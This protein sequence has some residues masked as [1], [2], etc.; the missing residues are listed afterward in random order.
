MIQQEEGSGKLQIRRQGI[1]GRES[2]S[3][4]VYPLHFILRDDWRTA[5]SQTRPPPELPWLAVI[6]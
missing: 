6:Y 5:I 2:R 3:A 4:A 1:E